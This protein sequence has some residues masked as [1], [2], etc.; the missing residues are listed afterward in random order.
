MKF[1]SDPQRLHHFEQYLVFSIMLQLHGHLSFGS[2]SLSLFT[3]E[4]STEEF[5]ALNS[6]CGLF[7]K[8]LQEKSIALQIRIAHHCSIPPI[9]KRRDKC[10]SLH[11]TLK[12]SSNTKATYHLGPILQTRILAMWLKSRQCLRKSTTTHKGNYYILQ[13]HTSKFITNYKMA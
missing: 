9:L 12:A 7:S 1:K 3:L 4:F 10:K 2:G 8:S 11:F 13:G 6:Y 5:C